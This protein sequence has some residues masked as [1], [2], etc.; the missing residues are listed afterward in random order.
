M[1]SKILFPIHIKESQ[2]LKQIEQYKYMNHF[3]FMLASLL[4]FTIKLVKLPLSIKPTFKNDTLEN[5]VIFY[6]LEEAKLNSGN[7]SIGKKLRNLHGR[8]INSLEK[9]IYTKLIY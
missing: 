8:R 9:A 3:L 6:D 5:E 4:I 1:K 2:T 7:K